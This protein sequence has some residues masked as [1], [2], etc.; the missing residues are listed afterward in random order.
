[1]AVASTLA[2]RCAGFL[3]VDDDLCKPPAEWEEQEPFRVAGK[4]S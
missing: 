3:E 4:E 2:K 1:M